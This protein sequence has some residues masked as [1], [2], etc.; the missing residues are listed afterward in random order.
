MHNPW[1][2]ARD[3]EINVFLEAQGAYWV[4]Y[5][6]IYIEDNSFKNQYFC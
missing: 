4:Y 2:R 5:I 3:K 6:Y 1:L